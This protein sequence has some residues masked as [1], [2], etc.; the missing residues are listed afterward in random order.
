MA[1]GPQPIGV[2]PQPGID[3]KTGLPYGQT[4]AIGPQPTA[5]TGDTNGVTPP[6]AQAVPPPQPI[7][8]G[9]QPGPPVAT[10]PTQG[11]S[12]KGVVTIGGRPPVSDTLITP[13]SGTGSAPV[14][15][16]PSPP[17]QGAPN[18]TS[19]NLDAPTVN[20]ATTTQQ[21]ATT[22]AQKGQ[23]SNYINGALTVP[24]Y[25]AIMAA[26]PSGATIKPG[27]VD[28][29]SPMQV[30]GADGSEI[31]IVTPN[32]DGSFTYQ[33]QSSGG[34][35]TG[36]AVSIAQPTPPQAQALTPSA[37]TPNWDTYNTAINNLTKTVDATDPTF[38]QEQQNVQT[39]LQAQ[40]ANAQSAQSTMA[41]R[42]AVEAATHGGSGEGGLSQA[43]AAQ[44]AIGGQ[45]LMN[46]AISNASQQSIAVAQNQ[47]AFRTQVAQQQ[48]SLAQ[49]AMSNATTAQD[50]DRAT[51]AITAIE[52]YQAN[53]SALQGL[54][55]NPNY[56]PDPQ[57][58]ASLVAAA[59]AGTS[60]V[61][62]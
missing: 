29:S 32:P 59:G 38:N 27:M 45:Q 20:T 54:L 36:V 21:A 24:V 51:Q 44:A 25:S 3:P 39:S 30:L 41:R 46:T 35:K 4:A 13:A 6:S 40:E 52:K 61:T 2:Q 34:T 17:D 33:P 43:G 12:Q 37:A 10:D 57:T 1:I 50:Q 31:G 5:A 23:Q 7:A 18:S 26:L 53:M 55:N 15:Q 60:L 14:A 28:G 49:E 19:L 47:V 42:A 11:T 48:L 56:T 58:I 16:T 9:P 22:P 8:I 62:G